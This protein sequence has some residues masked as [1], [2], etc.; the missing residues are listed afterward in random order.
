VKTE[1]MMIE[2]ASP[3][4]SVR[5][6]YDLHSLYYRWLVAPFER[7]PRTTALEEAA[8]QRSE[9]VLEVAVGP[10]LPFLDILKGVYANNVVEGVDVSPNMVER[11]RRLAH[12]AG[13]R[14]F[15]LQ[16]ADARDLPFSDA[17]FD[18]LFNSYMLDLISIGDLPV[19]LA[20]FRRVLKPEGRLVVLNMSKEL[21]QK[22]TVWEKVYESLPPRLVPYL[23]GSCRPVLVEQL[24]RDAGFVQV[25]RRFLGGL[26]QS[27]IA[28]G[29]TSG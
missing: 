2:A 15:H 21:G 29:R 22:R 27:E 13:F 5:R 1:G 4:G 14:N 18:I 7:R 25:H 24:V 11:T 16:V 20:E 19:I 17:S 28:T 6:A 3:A 8:I 26:L 23:L 10:G 12:S 9:K